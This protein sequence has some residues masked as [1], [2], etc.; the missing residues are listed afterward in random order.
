[1]VDAKRKIAIVGRLGVYPMVRLSLPARRILAYLPLRGRPIARGVASAEL[2]PDVPDD[3]GRAN[4]RRALWHLPRGWVSAV[5]DELVLDAESDL[6]QAHR[7]AACALDGKPLTSDEITLLSNDILPGWHEEWVCLRTR[8]STCF[9]RKPLRRLVVRWRRQVTMRLPRR[10]EPPRS[11]R[12][13]CASP[14]P[15]PS[16]LRTWHSAT[17]TRRRNASGR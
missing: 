16:S 3:V 11:R 17:D 14:P 8:C 10:R 1:M 4:L 2:W 12:S 6:A 5:G 13:L 15:R 7:V 9:A